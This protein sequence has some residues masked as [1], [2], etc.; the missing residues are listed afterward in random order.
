MKPPKER[1][2]AAGSRSARDDAELAQV[3]E[4]YL[5]DVEAGRP[6]EQERLISEHPAIAECLRAA[7]VSLQFIG[8]ASDSLSSSAKEVAESSGSPVSLGIQLGDYRI[9]REIGR[10]GMGIV[11]EAEQVSL[12]RRVAL[13]VLPFAAV[14]DPKHI[15]RFKN[16][17]HAAA[18]LHHTNIV[19]VFYVGCER[20]VYYYA[21]QYIEGRSLAAAIEELRKLAKLAGGASGAAG[22]LPGLGAGSSD[23][24]PRSRERFR[25]IAGLGLQAAQ[26]LA[27]AHELGVVHRDIKPA[28]LLIDTRG[29]VWITDFGLA[30]MQGDAN[31]TLSGDILGTL[32]Y[33]SPEQA[34]GKRAPVDHRTDI[35]SLGVTLYELLTL[36]PAV[37]GRDREEV[38]RRIAFE[39]PAPPRRL[40]RWIPVELETVVLKAMA[41]S[42]E[43]RYAAARELADDLTR[44]LEG[45][46]VQARRPGPIELA[47]RW[48]G[49]HRTLVVAACAI[50]VILISGLLAGTLLIWKEQ[51]QTGRQ[52]E[53]A[54][55]NFGLAREVVEEM[56]TRVADERL[57]DVPLME[58]VRRDLLEEALGF[59]KRLLEEEEGGSVV[60]QEASRAHL[61]VGDIRRLLGRP[62]EAEI[63]YRRA[64][65]LLAG[66]GDAGRGASDRRDLARAHEGLGRVLA[67]RGRHGE[68][69]TS[70]AEAIRIGEGVLRGAPD[71][72]GAWKDLA[73][74]LQCLADAQGKRGKDREAEEAC[75]RALE[76]QD[77]LVQ[78][79][80]GEQTRL[81]LA[82]SLARLARILEG[83]GDVEGAEQTYRNAL[84]LLEKLQ[85]GL[86]AGPEAR[87]ELAS[88]H[89][90]LGVL[91]LNTGRQAEGEKEIRAGLELR[92]RLVKDFPMVPDHRHHL[93]LSHAFLA[94]ALDEAGRGKDA[95]S[96]YRRA[97]E[98]HREV[99]REFPAIPR[100]RSAMGGTLHNFGNRLSNEGGREEAERAYREAVELAERL[101]EEAPGVPDHADQL[102][103][104]VANLGKDLHMCGKRSDA[105][106]LYERA[107]AIWSGLNQRHP[108]VLQHLVHL[109][110]V[111]NCLGVLAADEGRDAEAE[112][113]LRR[114]VELQEEA[115]R[116][117]PFLPASREILALNHVNLGEL[118]CKAGRVEEGE[119]SFERALA[120]ARSLAAEFPAVPRYRVSLVQVLERV[121]RNRRDS[122]RSAEALAAMQEAVE[123]WRELSRIST[124]PNH[125]HKL[126][127]A[128]EQLGWHLK[129]A[130]R[131]E[132]AVEAFREAAAVHRACCDRFPKE[133]HIRA[134]L[135]RDHM[136]LALVLEEARRFEEAE[137]A[138]RQVIELAAEALP[139]EEP[140]AGFVDHPVFR[141]EITRAYNDLGTLV[142]EMGKIDEAERVYRQGL[143]LA[144]KVA[145]EPGA[146]VED[147]FAL[148]NCHGNIANILGSTGLLEEAEE[149]FRRCLA[150]REKAAAETPGEPRYRKGLA[151]TLVRLAR[152]LARKAKVQ[153]AEGCYRKA[154][155]VYIKLA[156]EAPSDPGHYV[157]LAD[158]QDRLGDLLVSAGHPADA[159]EPYRKAVSVREK[160]AAEAPGDA[161]RSES[162]AFSLA[163]LAGV[164]AAT[165]RT[166]EAEGL[167][168]RTSELFSR[169]VAEAPAAPQHRENLALSWGR[170]GKLLAQT[171]RAGEAE[172]SLRQ[173]LKLE[174]RL[175]AEAPLEARYRQHVAD[176][177]SNLAGLLQRTGRFAEVIDAYRK[178]LAIE[179]ELA[180]ASP[181]DPRRWLSLASARNSLAWALAACPEPALRAP[182]QAVELARKAIGLTPEVAGIWNT[183]GVALYRSG[184]W[185]EAA[186]A[187]EKSMELSGGGDPN[188]WLFLAMAHWQVGRKDEARKWFSKAVVALEKAGEVDEEMRRFRAEAEGVLGLKDG[189]D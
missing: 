63:A 75:R 122:G 109:A 86:A 13:K 136:A 123:V 151:Q 85:P 158:C 9:L 106:P 145:A 3:L 69:E 53:K 59:Y 178:S 41:K 74:G 11:Y 182:V 73:E 183:L 110:N 187:L 163:E 76:I 46:P 71:D 137:R 1:T 179:E 33:M 181:E 79:K 138:Y 54:E 144:E 50:A 98:L 105:R 125:P 184:D 167:L 96:A 133:P 157:E 141:K 21:M 60:R 55:R 159:D 89:Q 37:K 61:R 8:D 38:L 126:G 28:N 169:L 66:P 81:A 4:A 175:A 121:A 31:L 23:L 16:E 27:H 161:R 155:A 156:E 113:V 10:G 19:P 185:K 70:F 20:G 176:T 35:Y 18:Q 56:L 14:L 36:E 188:D 78:A 134:D 140:G 17:A 93:A 22:S 172:M 165:G 114:A 120:S 111:R 95:D 119:G 146:G 128:H 147:V 87:A 65:E 107:L 42:P 12:G 131:P 101:V 6:V 24:S 84:E 82:S 115:V 7:F 104:H 2:E 94:L 72:R 100:Y 173:A 152:V 132:E 171:G 160:L 43:A 116:R 15:Q 48:A 130:G 177:H 45:K 129:G 30:R 108:E 64:V 127:H 68:A 149:A 143:V 80:G 26:G 5:A 49:R 40:N 186:A 164:L 117:A 77:R 34:L 102:A 25:S 124:D 162:L 57:L 91:L 148:S 58:D 32:R 112:E 118:L 47:A 51:R 150:L 62:D 103:L 67:D 44:F 90:K 29:N 168:R 180:G 99:V 170:L 139:G 166:E 154:I 39:D 153:E 97:L 83:K 92:D 88:A 174:E 189:K 135:A 142:Q 52:R